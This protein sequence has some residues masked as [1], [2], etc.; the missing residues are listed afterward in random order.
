MK[1]IEVY[2]G[3]SLRDN[4][5][6]TDVYFT[7]HNRLLEFGISGTTV[8]GEGNFDYK[9]RFVDDIKAQ[10]LVD[11]LNGIPGFCAKALDWENDR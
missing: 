5:D 3:K 7:L 10:K 9:F 6:K 8:I 11:A 4:P 1:N 2:L